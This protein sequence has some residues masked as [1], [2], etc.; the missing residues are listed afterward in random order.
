MSRSGQCLYMPIQMIL[1]L[2]VRGTAAKWAKHGCV[3]TYIVITDGN[4]GTDDLEMTHE[5]LAAT[6]RA[7]Q[8]APPTSPV[9][10]T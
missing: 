1:N 2:G 6:R 10:P 8:Q 5:K 7:E 9:S 3:V 4:I